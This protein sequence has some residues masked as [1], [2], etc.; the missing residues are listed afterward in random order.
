MKIQVLQENLSKAVSIC[1]RFASSRIQL[2]V[3]ANILLKTTKSKF[4]LSATNLEMSVSIS[5]GAKIEKEGQ[6]TVP[7]RVLN[8][9]ILNLNTGTVNLE[10]EKESL[11]ITNL[12]FESTISGMNASDFPSL[13]EEVG[14]DVLKISSNEILDAL[15]CTLFAVSS[16]ETRPVLTGT[17][18]IIK[19]S[20]LT[21]VATDGF[22]LSQ[23]KINISKVKEEK[24]MIL[25][26]N[27]LAELSRLVSGEDVQFSFKKSEKQVVFGFDDIILGSRIIEG[28]FPDFER[29]IPKETKIK[30]V[31]D[32]EEFL[33][34]VKL[35]SVFA[36]DAANVVKLVIDKDFIK[37]SAEGG[38]GSQTTKIEAKVDGNGKTDNEEFIIAF[39]YRFLEDFLNAVKGDDIQLEFSDPNAPAL[40]L[41][42]KDANF[43]HII[44]P[45]RLQS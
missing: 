23:K 29:I 6:I 15:S 36:R 24:K 27:A 1:S 41:D 4:T 17:L 16:D 22:R 11:R 19:E 25:P 44:M 26:K 34:G 37:I 13:P 9:L 38:Q 33:R 45:V 8:D 7:A 35:A 12:S 5:I 2:P 20:N 28:E 39:N 30:V 31:L 40:F 14:V 21:L 32:K 42:P 3:L 43:L 18:I 10:V